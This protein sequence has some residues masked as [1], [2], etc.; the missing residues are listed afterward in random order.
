MGIRR[1]QRRAARHRADA[2]PARAAARA[3]PEAAADSRARAGARGARALYPAGD[4]A[5]PS[6]RLPGA[7]EG[8]VPRCGRYSLHSREELERAM[9]LKLDFAVLGPVKPTTAHQARSSLAWDGFAQ[10]AG[11]ASIPVYAIGGLTRGDLEHA[12]R[13]GAHGLAMIRGSWV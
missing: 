12:W 10:V 4:R 5:R 7:G 8:A 6:P 3:G 13:A 11:G 9:R 2:G 1:H